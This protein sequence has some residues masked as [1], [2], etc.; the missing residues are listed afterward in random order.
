MTASHACIMQQYPP[1]LLFPLGHGNRIAIKWDF[2]PQSW[3]STT[4]FINAR[5]ISHRSYTP[6]YSSF[7][8]TF[9][10]LTN[11]KGLHNNDGV[12]N[13]DK[14]QTWVPQARSNE[15]LEFFLFEFST[16]T[17]PPHFSGR[18]DSVM[19]NCVLLPW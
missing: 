11:G 7:N 2:D 14:Y 1:A 5:C 16:F 19:C 9:C 6:I 4:P 8:T 3:C 12:L 10:D 15:V 17:P 18:L 13:C